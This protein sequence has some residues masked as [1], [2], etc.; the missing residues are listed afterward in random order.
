MPIEASTPRVI[1]DD[2]GRNLPRVNPNGNHVDN[3]VNNHINVHVDIEN[4]HHIELQPLMNTNDTNDSGTTNKAA[5]TS[6]NTPPAKGLNKA[7]NN[8]AS[9]LVKRFDEKV[10]IKHLTRKWT[11]YVQFIVRLMLVSSFLEDSIQTVTHIQEHSIEVSSQGCLRWL[12]PAANFFSTI[13]LL[14][15]I[16]AQWFGSFCLLRLTKTSIATN[17][18]ITWIIIQ[19]ILYGQLSNF[20]FIAESLSLTGGLLLLRAHLVKATGND[21]EEEDGATERTKL[22]GR[23]LLPAMYVFY[24]FNFLHS[25]L[26]SEETSNVANYIASLSKFV[27]YLGAVGGI[28]A[29]SF[30]VGVGLKSRKVAI[31]LAALNIAFIFYYHPFFRFVRREDGEWKYDL[32]MPMPNV[33][34]SS[35]VKFG[36]FE[37]SQIYYLH[38]YYFFLGLSTSGALMLLAQYGPGEIALQKDELILPTRAQD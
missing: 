25:A 15:G 26:T 29:G 8:N 1:A 4:N 11:P 37:P 12:G 20:E 2:I 34:V 27:F 16:V 31:M 10:N 36:D 22:L 35:D 18:L 28:G 38:R 21:Y 7:D 24:A 30:L 6:T 17:A 14:M 33:A 23:M 19:P 13:I 3:H 32:D 5:L 9:H